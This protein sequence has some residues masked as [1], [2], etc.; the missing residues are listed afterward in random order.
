[1]PCYYQ[2]RFLLRKALALATKKDVAALEKLSRTE[3]EQFMSQ[4]NK[5]E[6]FRDDYKKRESPSLC[7]RQLSLDGRMRNLGHDEE[8]HILVAPT[9]VK[10]EAAFTRK[11]LKCL[12]KDVKAKAPCWYGCPKHI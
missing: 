10:R 6:A 4:W 8:P 3:V 12:M 11:E 2:N 9:F 7:G 5:S 1:M